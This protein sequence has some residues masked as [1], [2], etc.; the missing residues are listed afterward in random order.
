MR[1]CS[2]KDNLYNQGKRI[3]NT[4]GFKGVSFNNK[5]KKYRA[6]ININGKLKHLGLF[7]SAEEAS[8]AYEAKAKELHKEFYY[9]NK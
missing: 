8:K 3:D 5:T 4:S 9:K 6:R 2:Q 1:W 7:E